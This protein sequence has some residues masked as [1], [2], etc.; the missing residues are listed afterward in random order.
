MR[1]RTHS[2]VL[3]TVQRPEGSALNARAETAFQDDRG[4]GRAGGSERR[5]PRDSCL[6]AG[7]WREPRRGCPD[8]SSLE[9]EGGRGGA[10]RGDWGC[11][12]TPSASLPAQNSQG[13]GETCAPGNSGANSGL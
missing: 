11:V 8:V 12:G 13:S 6:P 3:S 4:G 10:G 2:E 9:E 5:N 7:E 1:N